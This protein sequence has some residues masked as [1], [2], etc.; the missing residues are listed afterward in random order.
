MSHI[1]EYKM[2]IGGEWVESESGEIIERENPATCSVFATV[3]RANKDDV[4]KA[5]EAASE[6]FP[7]WS[8][9]TPDDRADYMEK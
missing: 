1:K 5:V 8:G 7:Y 9:L 4:D 6:A 3:P 2:Y